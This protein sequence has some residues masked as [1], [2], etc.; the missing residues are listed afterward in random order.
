MLRVDASFF[1][2]RFDRLTKV[3]D[4]ATSLRVGDLVLVT[5]VLEL[6]ISET[7]ALFHVISVEPFGLLRFLNC[8]GNVFD[9]GLTDCIS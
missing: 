1:E 3:P 4:A 9:H 7:I 6:A 2:I 5:Q 8:F